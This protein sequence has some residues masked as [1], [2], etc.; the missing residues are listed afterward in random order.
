MQTAGGP[1]VVSIEAGIDWIT[2]TAKRAGRPTDVLQ[3]GEWI[4]N[5]QQ[6]K[7]SKVAPL[8]IEGYSG[9]QAE[10]CAFGWRKDT[11]YL[12]LSGS[13]AATCWSELCSVSGSPTRLD[14][15]TTWLLSS[16]HKTLGSHCWR[17]SA[18][19]LSHQQGRP[20]KRTCSK[21]NQGLWLGSVG[22]RTGRRYIRIYDKGVE[23]RTHPQ[24]MRW[25][26]ELEAKKDLARALWTE[27]RSRTD[28][29]TW[30]REVVERSA[31]AVGGRTPTT[32][33]RSLE[34]LPVAPP[35]EL[36][37]IEQTRQWLETSVRP[38]VQRLL[39]ALPV[40]EVLK[41]LGL[42]EVALSV[43]LNERLERCL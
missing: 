43:E 37:S 40:E 9:L 13:L 27:A 6:S 17:A 22:T 25:R 5:Q 8:R 16:P 35:R 36:P 32:L 33:G 7:G 15:Q 12:R 42:N 20:L 24:G 3:F 11:D 41:V 18:A 23:S 38:S 31:V 30:C 14:V 4:V 39:L 10:Q 34:A 21:D 28:H 1:E 26:I 2:W 19:H 29:T